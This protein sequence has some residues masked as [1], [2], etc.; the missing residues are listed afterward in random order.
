[1]LSVVRTE[2]DIRRVTAQWRDRGERVA[3]V[4]TMG[5]LHAGH[6]SLVEEAKRHAD[7]VVVSIFVNPMQFNDS[8]DLDK[9]PRSL[10][11]DKAKLESAAADV[12]FFPEVSTIYPA[13]MDLAT[14]VVVP[15]LSEVLEG[16][17]RPGHFTG[18]TTVVCKLF[19]LV[20]PDCAVFGKKDYQQLLLIQ[21]M[22]EDLNLPINII[23]APTKREDDGLAMSSRNGNMDE[24]S[25]NSASKIHEIL[26]KCEKTLR[27]EKAELCAL[28]ATALQALSDAGFEP[29]YVAIRR[30]SD[31]LEPVEGD[32]KLVILVAAHF[33]GVRLIDN[34]ELCLV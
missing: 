9:Y 25:R 3:F 2:S 1:M 23:A 20:Q 5:N 13:G 16:E 7:R 10:E 4:P 34:V 17:H 12:M 30:Q 24:K 6:I 26:E 15:G 14:K 32:K 8:A 22:T 19:N 27:G 29:E 11:A 18:V 33:A 21:R 28:E 31:L